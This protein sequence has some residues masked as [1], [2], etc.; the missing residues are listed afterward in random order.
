MNS[1]IIAA[2]TALTVA[3]ASLTAAPAHAANGDTVNLGGRPV[4]RQDA[5]E[6][7][8]SMSS[9]K[10]NYEKA[11]GSSLDDLV[12]GRGGSSEEG[13]S[14]TTQVVISVLFAL[15]AVAATG[16][17]MVQEGMIPNPLPG[18][19]P[20]PQPKQDNDK[21]KDKRDSRH[22]DDGAASLKSRV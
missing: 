15:G 4:V 20:P 13:K 7:V 16:Y 11:A 1:R 17:Y 5:S 2:A 12:A 22:L 8:D 10:N 21:G 3:T 14:T 18:V 9:V 6:I 19:L